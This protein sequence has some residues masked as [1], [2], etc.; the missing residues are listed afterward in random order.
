MVVTSKNVGLENFGQISKSG[1]C[2]IFFADL[3][4]SKSLAERS[5]SSRA[6]LIQLSKEIIKDSVA[7]LTSWIIITQP[8]ISFSIFS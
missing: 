6:Q 5:Q 2:M 8:S 4:V 7:Q 1:F 3:K